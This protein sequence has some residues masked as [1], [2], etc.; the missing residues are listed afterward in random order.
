MIRLKILK[1]VLLIIIS[2]AI[3]ILIVDKVNVFSSINQEIRYDTIPNGYI[4]LKN[5][6]KFYPNLIY[7]EFDDVFHNDL[8]EIK[9]NNSVKAIGII[10]TN[11]IVGF[12]KGFTIPKKDE[13]QTILIKI[14]GIVKSRFIFNKK[15]SIMHVSRDLDNKLTLTYT[16]NI[17]MYD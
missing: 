6:F 8:I 17:W 4:V 11:N 7:F 12:A 1:I 9:S 14:N 2:F 13:E 10:S 15:F 5:K 16:I 3:V